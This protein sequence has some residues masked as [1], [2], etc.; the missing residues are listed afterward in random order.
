MSTSNMLR[1]SILPPALLVLI[2]AGFTF[3][4]FADPTPLGPEASHQ[5]VIALR[6]WLKEPPAQRRDVTGCAFATTPLTKDDAKEAKDL[7]WAEHVA[8][9]KADRKA[10]MDAKSVT[11]DALTM[12]FETVDFGS[13]DKPP[14]SGR[15]LFLSMHGGGGAPASVNE[16]QWRNQVQLAK[17]YH[18]AEGIYLAPRAPTDTWDLWHQPHID[19]FFQRLI[20]NLI[21]LGNVNPN[22]VYV[23]GYSAGGDGVYQLGPR[24]ADS[25]AAAS[26]MAGHPNDAS[27]LGLRNIGF[28]IQVGANDGAY[29]RNQVAAEWGGKLDELQKADPTGYAHFTELHEGKAHW[30]DM[31]DRKAI[32]WMEKFT[33]NPYPQKVVWHQSNVTHD[34]FYWLAVPK[35][36][37]HGGQDIV[38][39]LKDHSVEI[40]GKEPETISVRLNDAMLDLDQPVVITRNGKEVFRGQA[41]R[42]I[43]TLEKT[44]EG[45]GDPDLMFSAEIPAK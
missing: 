18:P 30:M 40:T 17:G 8:T 42:T 26:M 1:A 19:R 15:S 39:E 3:Q 16:S 5:A 2:S 36:Q 4:T 12:K 31:E 37:A 6:D 9:I 20:E 10:E 13:P 29:H 44:L 35:E 22:R 43:A 14:A 21:V 25:W 45:R 33:R 38:A 11:L 23:M 24:M 34:R 28:A 7:L 27:P 41:T 32:P